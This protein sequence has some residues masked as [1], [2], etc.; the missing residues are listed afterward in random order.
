MYFWNFRYNTRDSLDFARAG[1]KMA[2]MNKLIAFFNANLQG[3]DKTIRTLVFNS[4]PKER[5]AALVRAF[6]T[7]DAGLRCLGCAQSGR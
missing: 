3:I 6:S 2:V 7:M 5:N 1:A 4:D